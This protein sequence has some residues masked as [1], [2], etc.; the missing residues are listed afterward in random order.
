MKDALE[1]PTGKFDLLDFKIVEKN[2]INK[3]K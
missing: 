2:I 1:Q 3:S